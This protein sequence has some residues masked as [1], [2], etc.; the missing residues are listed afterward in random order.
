MIARLANCTARL[1]GGAMNA[2]KEVAMNN[3]ELKKIIDDHKEWLNTGGKHCQRANLHGADLRN[4]DLRWAYLCGADLRSADLRNANLRDADLRGAKNLVVSL[5]CPTHGSF[6][7]WKKCKQNALVKLL[8]PEDAKRLSA[9]TEKCRCDK[10][11]VLAI[12]MNGEEVEQAV[13]S[14]S[15]S[16]VYRVGEM[17]EVKDF[18]DNRWNECSTG[19]HFFVD[20][21]MAENYNN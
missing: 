18:D 20:K 15:D 7:A 21:T 9:T 11:K 10:A 8:I 17:V 5:S 19:I 1:S 12:Y 2:R 16:F 6:I 3:E 13:S 14:Y 4:A